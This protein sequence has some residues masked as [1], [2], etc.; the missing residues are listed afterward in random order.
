MKKLFW[1]FDFISLYAYLQSTSLDTLKNK[2]E[3]E[4]VPLLFAGLL[5]FWGQK[6][7]AEIKAKKLFT[8]RQ[9]AWRANQNNIPYR[10]PPKHP[11]NP[12]RALRLS[13]ALGN[14]LT[15]IQKI[16]N[17]LEI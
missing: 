16:F 8:F 9:C 3:I 14:D 13:I 6:G 10:T 17:L 15:I 2:V 4:C 1:Y 7:P 5:D 11:F 12:L